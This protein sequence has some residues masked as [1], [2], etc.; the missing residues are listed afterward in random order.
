MNLFKISIANIL[1][2][3]LN[4]TLSLLLLS[5][6]VGLVSLLLLM[7]VQLSDQFHKNIDKIDL[8]LGAKGSPMQLILSSVYQVDAPTGN[9]AIKDSRKLMKNLFVETA[10]PLAYGDSYK[11]Y[12]IV[13]TTQDYAILFEAE[14]KEGRLWEKTFEVCIGGKVAE[15]SGLKI[16]D[17][18]YSSHGLDGQGESHDDQAFTVVGIYESNKTVVDKVITTSVKSMWD[19]HDHGHEGHDHE[20]HDHE[21]HD[22][23]EHEPTDDTTKE[24]L[25]EPDA[26]SLQTGKYLMKPAYEDKE[27][28]AAFLVKNSDNIFNMVMNM[29]RKSDLQAVMPAVEVNR[30]ENNFGIGVTTLFYL[31]LFIGILSILSVFISLFNSLKERKYELALMRTMGASRSTLFILILLEGILLS[32]VG[33]ILG[34]TF[35]RIGLW[36]IS[37]KMEDNFQYSIGDMNVL[38]ME[39]ILLALTLFIGFLAA[40]LPAYSAMRI[41]ISKTLSNA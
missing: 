18:F 34:L 27:I 31:S 9:I 32:F 25:E 1:N 37:N 8:V 2:K 30:L 33:Y 13:G 29:A 24:T 21:G 12:R 17:T 10:I 5:F 38:P 4:A 15:E 35:S 19:I 39:W 28:T 23:A 41:D 3:P 20:G 6:G 11:D 40:F 36:I 22:H 16:G 7:Q 14:L 26:E